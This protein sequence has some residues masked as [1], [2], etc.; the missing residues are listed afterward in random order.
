ML[1]L[2]PHDDSSRELGPFQLALMVISVALLS[3]LALDLILPLPHEIAHLIHMVD[4]MICGMLLTDFFWRFAHARSKLQ[5]MRWGWVDLIASIPAIETLRWGRLF[6]VIRVIRLLF[7]L[8]SYRALL[9]QFVHNRRQAGLA[10]AL[11]LTFFVITFASIGMLLVETA[12]ESN[13]KTAEDAL[14]W[15]MVSITTIGYGDRYPV[16][17]LGRIIAS[18]LMFSGIGLFGTLSGVAASFFLGNGDSPKPEATEGTRASDAVAIRALD[19]RI[20]RLEEQSGQGG[21]THGITRPR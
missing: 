10:S 4:T 7:A 8:R 2:V 3:A 13:I 11:V 9:L 15:S 6:R 21:T 12:P 1:R 20:R 16:T 19:E 18:V 14:W 17:D 5:F